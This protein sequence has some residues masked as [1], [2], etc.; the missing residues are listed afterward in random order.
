MYVQCL[1]ISW[2]FMYMT[3]A[4]YTTFRI[5]DILVQEWIP[6]KTT[7]RLFLVNILL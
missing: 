5:N 1:S 4:S 3:G 6:S 7:S 2:M